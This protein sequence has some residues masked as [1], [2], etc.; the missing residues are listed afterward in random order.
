MNINLTV[1]FMKKSFP[2]AAHTSGFFY[3]VIRA[4]DGSIYAIRKQTYIFA[5]N[6]QEQNEIQLLQKFSV[7]SA[8]IVSPGKGRQF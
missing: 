6:E 1:N 2:E 3:I 7:V 8:V 5:F 4:L